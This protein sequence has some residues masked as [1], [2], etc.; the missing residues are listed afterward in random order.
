M[1]FD[2]IFGGGFSDDMANLL[3]QE[4]L[5]VQ[6]QRRVKSVIDDEWSGTGKGTLD[7]EYYW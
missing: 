6:E 3:D 1:K 5:R 4:D 7:E 2:D